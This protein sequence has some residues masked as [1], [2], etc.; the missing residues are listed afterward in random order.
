[1]LAK[2]Y[3]CSASY[4][5]VVVEYVAVC[6]IIISISVYEYIPAELRQPDVKIGQ[7]RRF[8]KA[9]LFVRHCGA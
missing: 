3:F 8:L 2:F 5:I 6:V 7:F 1:L 4:I 9:F